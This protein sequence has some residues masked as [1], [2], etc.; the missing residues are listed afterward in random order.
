MELTENGQINP[1]QKHAMIASITRLRGIL[2]KFNL[3]IYAIPN[4]G[5]VLREKE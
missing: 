4:K 3:T 5:Y 2:E 1:K